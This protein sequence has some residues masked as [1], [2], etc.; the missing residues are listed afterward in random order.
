MRRLPVLLTLVILAAAATPARAKPYTR[1][2]TLREPLGYTWTDELVHRDLTIAEKNVAAETFSLADP[3][4][5]PVPLQVE[6]L[7]G[8]ATAVSRVRLWWKATL[9]KDEAVRY[10]L[11]YRDDG[12][13]G[14]RPAGGLTGC[15]QGDRLVLST[16]VAEVAVPAP[17]EAYPQP[18]PLAEAPAPVL[19]VRTPPGAGP[20]LG[21]WRLEGPGRVRRV[22]TSV[23]ADGPL[24]ARAAIRYTFAD[25]KQEY[26]VALEAVAGEPWFDLRETYRLG[27]GDRSRLTLHEHLRPTEALWLPWYTDGGEPQRAYEVRRDLLATRDPGGEPFATLRP[28]WARCPDT[29]QVCLAVGEDGGADRAAVGAV[30]VRPADWVRPY[31]QFPT[32]RALADGRGMAFTFPLVA[33]RRAWALVAGPV[34][35]FETKGDLQGLIRRMADVPLDRVLNAY[36]LSWERDPKRAAPHILTTAKRLRQIRADVGAVRDTAPARLVRAALQSEAAEERFLAEF[37]AG[38]RRDL[39]SLGFHAGVILGRSY[40]DA[41]LT[42]GAY[43]NRLPEALAGADLAA[44]GGPAG[45]PAV[46]LLGYVFTDPHFGRAPGGWDPAPADARAI[47]LTVP[48]YAAAMMPD[49]PH[50]KRWMTRALEGFRS[51]LRRAVPD[52]KRES[53]RPDRLAG[54]LARAL[55]VLKAARSAGFADPFTWPEVRQGLECLRNLHGPPDPRLG[56][57]VLVPFGEMTGWNDRL[58]RLFGIAAAGVRPSDADLAAVWMGLYRAYYG[59]AG[60]GDLAADVLLADPSLKA[61]DLGSAEWPSRAY[62]GF[63]A[64]LRSRAGSPRETFVAL[65]CGGSAAGRG[66]AMSLHLAGAGAP[67]A[68]AWHAPADVFLPQEYL[69]NRVT[70]GENENMDAAGRLVLVARS[71]AADVAVAEARATHLRR[72][73]RRPEEATPGTALARRRLETPARYRR[74]VMLVKHAAG[75]ALEDYVVVRDD[76]A[77]ADPATFNLF[78]L[79]RRAVRSG[80][81]LRFEGQLAADAVLYL[82]SP[83][84][85]SATLTEWGWPA[86]DR[87]ALIPPGYEPGREPWRRGEVQQWVRLRARPGA[88]FLTVVYPYPKGGAEPTFEPL[89]GGRGVRVSVGDDR[90][91]VYL[92][93]DPPK[94]AGGQV[95]VVRG[96]KRTVVVEKTVKPL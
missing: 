4:G 89:A 32:V 91:D 53:V 80:R 64:V 70:L 49:H 86:G 71:P 40:Q 84:V 3:D 39:P 90:E 47:L 62:A 23:E 61:A 29:A 60:S 87:S 66:D 83:V 75:S 51:D 20:W 54:A 14:R 82:A 11:T 81:C 33:G 28:R 13:P 59:D 94:A 72:M 30:M 27:E 79:A 22:Q 36:T 42:P 26:E 12:R 18:L 35:R 65:R 93:A 52:G 68:P 45:S 74:W 41:F 73:P 96:G 1:P 69:H 16:G 24:R 85:Q 58:G 95:A 76:L 56:R 15:R 38:R 55:P 7:K 46:A 43:P 57:R 50:A 48:A 77:A 2:L 37:L 9:P 6:V 78:V 25:A 21:T 67:I 17:A 31:A 5:E 34:E 63:G 19:G 92:S 88:G 44:A 8:K 10:R